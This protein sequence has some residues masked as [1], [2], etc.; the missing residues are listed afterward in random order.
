MV[1][2]GGLQLFFMSEVP[3][4]VPQNETVRSEI[5]GADLAQS[6]H[7]SDESPSALRVASIPSFPL[8]PHCRQ[9]RFTSRGLDTPK[10]ARLLESPPD[11]AHLRSSVGVENHHYQHGNVS[12]P[13]ETCF[14]NNAHVMCTTCIRS[15]V[16]MS[17]LR[18][19]AK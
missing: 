2:L 5:R 1:V 15:H 13:I 14:P 10:S 8:Q 9:C 12:T 18:K 3:Y 11:S 7:A 17:T 16:A 19:S 4:V 6:E